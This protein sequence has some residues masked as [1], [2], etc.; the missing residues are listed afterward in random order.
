VIEGVRVT[1]KQ[2]AG[3]ELPRSKLFRL[4]HAFLRGL[5]TACQ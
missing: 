5:L 4:V 1:R 3:P 2:V